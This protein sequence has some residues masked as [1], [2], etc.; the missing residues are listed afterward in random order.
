MPTKPYSIIDLKSLVG[1]IAQKYGVER[2]SIFGSYAR[3]EAEQYS[4]IDLCIDKGKIRDLFELSGFYTDLEE[5]LDTKIDI[6]TTCG[7]KDDFRQHIEKEM[8]VIYEQRHA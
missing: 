5:A 1:S 2:V 8:T 7:L 4:D 3:G 6:I